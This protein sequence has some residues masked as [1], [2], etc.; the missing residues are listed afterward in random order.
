MGFELAIAA[1]RDPTE[2]REPVHDRGGAPATLTFNA[3]G[4]F[5]QEDGATLAQTID[6]AISP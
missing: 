1:K 5:A 4:A 2:G 6:S 3:N